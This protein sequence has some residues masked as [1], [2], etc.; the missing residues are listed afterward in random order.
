MVPHMKKQVGIWN[1]TR[2]AVQGLALKGQHALKI[3]A[4]R[5]LCDSCR[6][7]WGVE[8]GK[9]KPHYPYINSNIL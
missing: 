1:P 9:A 8:L 5:A 2:F 4:F 3:S 7:D 6:G